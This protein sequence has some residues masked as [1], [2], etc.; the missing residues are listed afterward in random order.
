M[1]AG[2]SST[3]ATHQPAE[4]TIERPAE[5]DVPDPLRQRCLGRD[6]VG[7]REARHDEERLE[8][9]G[10]E[11]Q[12]DE[13]PDEHEPLREVFSIDFIVA[14]AASTMRKVSRASGLLNRNISTATGVSARTAPARRPA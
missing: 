13:D 3:M 9:L 11:G 14:Q 8:G 12:T 4:R 1:L 2:R 6:E 10:E 7:Q 5:D